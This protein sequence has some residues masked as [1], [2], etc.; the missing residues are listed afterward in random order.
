MFFW[1]HRFRTS[2]QKWFPFQD[3]CLRTNVSS[4]TVLHFNKSF[5]MFKKFIVVLEKFKNDPDFITTYQ[6]F[7]CHF[8]SRSKGSTN[9]LDCQEIYC[10]C[11]ISY[12]KVTRE[13]KVSVFWYQIYLAR[14]QEWLLNHNAYRDIENT[15]WVSFEIK[16]P[17][18]GF[19]NACWIAMLAE[20]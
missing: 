13:Y 14:L 7:F 11:H 10:Y 18:Q 2:V 16:C 20:I 15:R 6:E 5:L 9:V 4:R 3:R 12:Y 1:F 17:R 8:K 19:E